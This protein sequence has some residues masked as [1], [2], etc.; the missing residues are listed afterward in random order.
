MLGEQ[1]RGGAAADKVLCG[2]SGRVGALE[3][4]GE[5][6]WRSGEGRRRRNTLVVLK[7]LPNL[8]NI[9]ERKRMKESREDK[10]DEDKRR[11]TNTD[12]MLVTVKVCIS[13]QKVGWR[14]ACVAVCGEGGGW[15]SPF[16]GTP[17]SV[18]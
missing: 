5:G 11:R 18:E 3:E 15:D 8:A 17:G 12:K 6:E 16:K 9:Y 2:D 4:K 13:L 10:K 7:F 14:R 1:D